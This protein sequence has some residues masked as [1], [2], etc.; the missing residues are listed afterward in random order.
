LLI[1][2]FISDFQPTAIVS[3]LSSAYDQEHVN[4]NHR[5]IDYG[6]QLSKIARL[7]YIEGWSQKQ[8]AERYGLSI[9]T[10]SRALARARQVGVVRI[11]VTEGDR[12]NQ[13]LEVESE[14]ALGIEEVVI[15]AA[16]ESD[17]VK[18]AELAS[19]LGAV[20]E[21]RL[22]PESVVG[23]GWG[24]TLG[25]VASLLPKIGPRGNAVVPIVGALGATDRNIYPNFIAR[26]LATRIEGEAYMINGPAVFETAE[27][28]RLFAADKSFQPIRSLWE[29]A[30]IAVLGASDLSDDTSMAR[31]GALASAEL[32]EL[33]AGGAVCAYNFHFLDEAGRSVETPV[34]ARTL[35]MPFN[36]LRSVPTKIIV[37]FGSQKVM[38]L[39]VLAA[40]SLADVLVTDEPTA[41][42]LLDA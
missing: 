36:T 15:V 10:V 18:W 4:R 23:V 17:N 26:E 16:E 24:E 19:A 9:A 11:E 29:R 25:G 22:K 32:R 37:A 3:P 35:T 8:I 34:A 12:P 33:R 27:A 31:N 30:D 38:P 28:C 6:S 42:A 39:A 14:K 41:R 21:R 7:Y 5:E 20:L 1:L 2:Q 13:T 40:N